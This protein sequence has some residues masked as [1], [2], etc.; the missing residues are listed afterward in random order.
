MCSKP[1]RL[2]SNIED[3]ARSAAYNWRSNTKLN[4]TLLVKNRRE[5]IK[6]KIMWIIQ[7]NTVWKTWVIIIGTFINHLLPS[8]NSTFKHLKI[9]E[10]FSWS[11]YLNKGEQNFKSSI[12]RLFNYSSVMELT[13]CWLL[14]SFGI[15]AVLTP[16]EPPESRV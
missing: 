15:L 5:K 4:A 16:S 9:L 3:C 6:I 11:A 12:S 8:K 10:P 14:P 13:F 1:A 7:G 2:P